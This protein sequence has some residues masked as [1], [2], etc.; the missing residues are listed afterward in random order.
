MK[1]IFKKEVVIE[2]FLKHLLNS[3]YLEQFKTE[4][5]GNS[6]EY[7]L[8][9]GKLT[10]EQ[11]YTGKIEKKFERKYN[12]TLCVNKP[13]IPFL[14]LPFHK[15]FPPKYKIELSMGSW[16]NDGY[17]QHIKIEKSEFNLIMKTFEDNYKRVIGNTL[18]L[19]FFDDEPDIFESTRETTTWKDKSLR[20]YFIRKKI[21]KYN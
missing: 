9:S 1:N 8:I 14:L 11:N 7:T 3:K 6:K 4:K 17:Y 12:M 15:M 5:R 2:K 10:H 13:S 20:I 19:S 21:V 18:D 16:N